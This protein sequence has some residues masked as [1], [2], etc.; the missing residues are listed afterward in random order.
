MSKTWRTGRFVPLI[1][2]TLCGAVTGF[3]AILLLVTGS[4]IL[5]VSFSHLLRVAVPVGAA[6]GFVA[7][8]FTPVRFRWL[9]LVV[10]GVLTFFI[11]GASFKD[12]VDRAEVVAQ[13]YAEQIAML[14]ERNAALNG[15]W[16]ADL[17]EVSGVESVAVPPAP[18]LSYPDT[19]IP[20][21]A[22]FFLA[23]EAQPPRLFVARRDYG[24]QYDFRSKKWSRL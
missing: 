13:R 6:I 20:K 21:I 1:T 23:Y 4:G 24:L 15:K 9:R 12:V 18:Y 17:T 8:A 22:G 16:P 3:V 2:T 10:T 7:A 19:K 5:P 14:V 11:A